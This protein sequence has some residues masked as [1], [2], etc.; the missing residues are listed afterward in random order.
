MKAII[1]DDNM[2]NRQIFQ[3][4]LEN[5]GYEVVST[6]DGVACIEG[7]ESDNFDLVILDVEMPRLNGGSVLQII[8]ESDQWKDIPVIIVTANHHMVS[9]ELI[10]QADY[11]L[12]KPIDV[13]LFKQLI[14]RIPV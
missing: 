14:Q 12:H 1:A 9:D 10:E 8:R 11:V 6:E 4:S 13:E 2:F 3:L 5:I 7:L